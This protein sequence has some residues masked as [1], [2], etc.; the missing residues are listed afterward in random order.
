M[1]LCFF[2]L[3]LLYG[4]LQFGSNRPSYRCCPKTKLKS[5]LFV[6]FELAKRMLALD[7]SVFSQV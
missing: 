7:L 5:D 3:C 1:V 6:L 4:S 2:S